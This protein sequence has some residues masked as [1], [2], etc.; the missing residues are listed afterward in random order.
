MAGHAKSGQV[1]EGLALDGDPGVVAFDLGAAHDVVRVLGVAMALRVR[2]MRAHLVAGPFDAADVP[3]VEGG[4]RKWIFI[5]TL[6][7]RSSAASR[8]SV[9]KKRCFFSVGERCSAGSFVHSHTWRPGQYERRAISRSRS[10][11]T[12]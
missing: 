6:A 11:R 1:A 10:L 5:R 12:Q 3:G 4:E 2:A 7:E 9:G 8:T